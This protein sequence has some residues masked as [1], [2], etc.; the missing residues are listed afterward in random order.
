MKFYLFSN[1]YINL[2]FIKNIVFFLYKIV[3]IYFFN[4]DVIIFIKLILMQVLVKT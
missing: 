2:E 1:I 4:I 3:V